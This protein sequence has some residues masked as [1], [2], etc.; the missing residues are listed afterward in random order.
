M[1]K[2]FLFIVIEGGGVMHEV[3]KFLLPPPGPE[4]LG[5][6]GGLKS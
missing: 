6:G 2:A 4:G 3:R 5:A 1:V